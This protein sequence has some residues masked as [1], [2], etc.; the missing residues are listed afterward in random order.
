MKI[1]I[2]GLPGSGKTTLAKELAYHFLVP[3]HNADTVREM[4]NDWDFS[5]EGRM[6]Q[7]VRM[8]CE[9][10]ILDFVCPLNAYR[11]IVD[12]DF[13]IW[14]DTIDNSRYEDTNK[15]FEKP[16]KYD[17]RIQ[18]WIGQNQL[19]N[20]LVDFSPGMKDIKLFLNGPMQK[21]VK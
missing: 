1:L 14:M 21:L 15:L 11:W 9:Y 4:H 17:L 16:I 12:P 7:A 2:M 19:R 18:K 10:G 20:C 13:I 3:H 8:S 6:R 5:P